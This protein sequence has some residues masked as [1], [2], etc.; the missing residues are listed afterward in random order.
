M[1]LLTIN[2]VLD[3]KILHLFIFPVSLSPISTLLSQLS[4]RYRLYSVA[5]I[6][7]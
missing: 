3:S 2:V 7:C 6:I 1:V 4:T 5:G